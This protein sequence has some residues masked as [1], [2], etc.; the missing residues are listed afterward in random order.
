MVSASAPTVDRVDPSP[1]IAARGYEPAVV[2]IEVGGQVACAG[3]L[4]AADVVIT[5]RH[6]VS[7][8]AGP[9]ACPGNRAL[10]AREVPPSAIA[11]R[12]G[13]DSA[14]ALVRAHGRATL[15]QPGGD[16]CDGDL[17]L[18]LL[19]TAIGTV[20]PLTVRPTGAAVAD[21][22]RTLA[23]IG[24]GLVLRDHVA[25]VGA[26][27]SELRLDEPAEPY[28]AGGPAIDEA[29]GAIV[30]V[31]SRPGPPGEG[32]LYVRTDAFAALFEVAKAESAFGSP[33][34]GTHLLKA[35]AGPADMGS[36]CSGGRDCA[37]GAC[38]SL[39]DAQYCS[40]SCGP[41]DR[42]P[43]TFRCEIARPGGAVCIKA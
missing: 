39:G 12:T 33:T 8:L 4:V 29:T 28:G 32:L 1:G 37:A 20:V 24:D 36:I 27:A 40:R 10:P 41:H 5:A 43:A 26:A 16:F 15:V 2:S 6:C 35:H 11:V 13:D 23:W 38:V 9:V 17:A 3:A 25:V 19:D 21:H 18:V 14:S 31:A 42:C 34:S 22:V 7:I 30:G